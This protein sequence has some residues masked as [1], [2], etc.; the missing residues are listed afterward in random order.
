MVAPTLENDRVKLILLGMSNYKHLIDIAQEDKLIQYSPY[1]ID[2]PEDLKEYVQ[3]AV[4]YYYH[5]T[6]IP[7]IVFDKKTRCYAGS[8]RFMNI[9][10][11]NK[12]AEIGS[13]WIG[14][15]FQA[16]GLNKNMKFLMLQYAFEILEMDRIEFRIDERNIRSRK[17]VEKLGATYEGLLRKNILML[18]GFKR[19]TCSYSILKEEW[20]NIKNSIFKD[21]IAQKTSH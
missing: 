6:A 2:T 13:T 19:S 3:T 20:P 9:S 7:F 17:A 4:D 21:L 18:D 11:N 10:W 16:T 15:E 8:T 5:K 12:V 1:K 14:K